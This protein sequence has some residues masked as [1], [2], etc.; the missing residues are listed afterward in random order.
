MSETSGH[1]RCAYVVSR[2][3]YVSHTFIRREVRALRDLGVDLHTATV[4]RADQEDLPSPADREEARTTYSILPASPWRLLAAH[5]RAV[6]A[7][8]IGY[9]T[10]F[11]EA[12]RRPR[13]SPRALLWQVFYFV[14]AILLWDWM[15]AS[16]LRHVHAHHANVA[17]DLAMLAAAFGSRA[18]QHRWMWSFTLHGPTELY[19]V[20]ET[21]LAQKV[22]RADAVV[23]ISDF[24]RSQ[25]M[26]VAPASVWPKVQVVHCGIDPDE[27]P[28]V[29]RPSRAGRQFRVLTVARLEDRKGHELLLEALAELR[30]RGHDIALT[31]AGD[32]PAR[33]RIERRVSELRLEEAV[34]LLGAVDHERV[35]DL[36]AEAD[37]F[38]LPSFAEGVPVVLMEA[39]ASGL[40]VIATRVMGVPE[41]VEHEVSG[42]LVPPGRSDAIA[43]ALTRLMTDRASVAELGTAGRDRVL[44]DFDIRDSAARL[45]DLFLS[46]QARADD[47]AVDHDL[48][49]R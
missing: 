27:F 33:A 38:C 45:N 12:I 30:H 32:G 16:N 35:G 49:P 37:A 31:V 18:S 15:R 19:D 7:A 46:L 24:A 42:L 40:P 9:L 48:V 1:V 23:C 36:H 28:P 25:A 41:L 17:G 13:P 22:E 26:A 34:T 8:P 14:E 5:A 11:A 4:R 44:A 43:D 29:R 20:V 21:K 6:R 39:M 47:R 2:Y 10:T 3:P